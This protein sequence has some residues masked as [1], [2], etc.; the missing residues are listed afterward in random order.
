[1]AITSVERK[2]LNHIDRQRLTNLT[3]DLVKIPSPTGHEV[4]IAQFYADYLRRLGLDVSLNYEYPN[5]P[6]VIAWLRG[7]AGG[8]TF[9]LN[10]HMDTIPLEDQPA[11]FKEGRVYGRGACDQKAGVAGMAEAVRA[12]IESGVKLKGNILLT[13]T[14]MHERPGANKES[15]KF[16]AQHGPLGD[17][18]LITEGPDNG[19]CV[20]QKGLVIFDITISREGTT[21]HEATIGP[22]TPNPLWA[23]WRMMEL[24]KKRKEEL[25]A[26]P[27]TNKYLPPDS[28]YVG[29]FQSGEFFNTLP[30]TCRIWG[31]R[32]WSPG[33]T[34]E[35]V[36]GEFDHLAQQI[37]RETGATVR[38]DLDMVGDPSQIDEGEPIV[39]L[40]RIA[41]KD[42][43][44]E[45]YP[46]IGMMALGDAWIFNNIG[47]VPTTYYAGDT[48]R[49]HATP[50]YVDMAKMLRA[51]KVYALVALR[52]VGYAG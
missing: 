7:E 32:R 34:Y 3:L 2:V 35:E 23:G 12:I 43:T 31:T 38:V 10:G 15:I 16:L 33:I 24:L 29:L 30:T 39:G 40:L 28:V 4:P 52:Y 45:E 13:A 46:I 11:C 27:S 6:T 36:A 9:Q 17:T 8:P 18:I 47:H 19:V 37:E 5:G 49:A 42:L 20:V 22:T 48:Q 14:G 26:R 41:H 21:I 44:G 25:A 1:V 50:E 51:A